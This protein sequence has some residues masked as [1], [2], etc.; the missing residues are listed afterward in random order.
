MKTTSTDNNKK[1]T[2]MKPM[3]LRELRHIVANFSKRNVPTA[4]RFDSGS[5]TS[6]AVYELIKRNLVKL[7]RINN[8]FF[9]ISPASHFF[10]KLSS[11]EKKDLGL[12]CH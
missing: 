12:R 5:D 11:K 8:Y 4:Y 2:I 9:F 1:N 6:K 7:V 10:W 3:H